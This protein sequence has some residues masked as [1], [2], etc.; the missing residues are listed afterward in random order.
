MMDDKNLLFSPWFR[1]IVIKWLLSSNGWWS[2]LKTTMEADINCDYKNI[3]CF[4]PPEEHRG[5]GGSAGLLFLDD[6]N[7]VSPNDVA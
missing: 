1:L 7:H 5:G 3:H 6:I 2:N 4:D